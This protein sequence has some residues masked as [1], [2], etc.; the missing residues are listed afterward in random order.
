MSDPPLAAS[1]RERILNAARDSSLVLI[2]GQAIEAWARYLDISA[3]QSTGD[4][5]FQGSATDA[6]RLAR[7]LA[8]PLQLF[9]PKDL[10]SLVGVLKFTD[11][12]G[13]SRAIDVLRSP[14]GLAHDD[15]SRHAL[16]LETAHGSRLRLMHPADCVISKLANLEL[17]NKQCPS[18]R[19]QAELSLRIA[20]AYFDWALSGDF[21]PQDVRSHRHHAKRLHAFA[22][23]DAGCHAFKHH[24]LDAFEVVRPRVPMD[25]DFAERLYPKLRAD[26]DQLQA[27]LA[28]QHHEVSRFVRE[29]SEGK[30][31]L[32]AQRYSDRKQAFVVERS[33]GG[34]GNLVVLTDALGTSVCASMPSRRALLDLSPGTEVTID[35]GGRVGVLRERGGRDR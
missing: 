13:V 7:G 1:D 19:F 17:P 20:T 34:N 26:L 3:L 23:S 18:D 15:V 4:V 16:G 24:G 21:K 10:T 5:D 25:T 32:R 30:G 8:Y 14:H 9:Q 33:V 12:T 2:G 35:A 27:Q 29:Q 22:R 11:E 31:A 28:P 6:Q